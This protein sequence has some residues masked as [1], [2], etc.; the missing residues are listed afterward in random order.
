MTSSNTGYTLLAAII[1]LE[2]LNSPPTVLELRALHNVL[3][4]SFEFR[5]FAHQKWMTE[6]KTV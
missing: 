2:Q 1:F 3:S 4:S 5:V 6:Q